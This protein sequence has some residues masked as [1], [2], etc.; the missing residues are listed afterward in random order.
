M[1]EDL[2]DLVDK[3]ITQ[4]RRD[5]AAGDRTAVEELLM[6]A[7]QTALEAYLPEEESTVCWDCH[8]EGTVP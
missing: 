7:P 6:A 3:V 2:H 8:G 4:I 1:N 5:F